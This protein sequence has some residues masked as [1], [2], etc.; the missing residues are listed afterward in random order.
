VRVDQLNGSISSGAITI[1]G[2]SD[3]QLTN[4][5]I[6]G[7]RDSGLYLEGNARPDVHS[8]T[9]AES[10]GPDIEVRTANSLDRVGANEVGLIEIRGTIS[11]PIT[12]RLNGSNNTDYRLANDITIA[13]GATLTIEPG[14]NVLIP[15]TVRDL[16]V[17]GTLLAEGTAQD[18][19]R[20]R[21]G[22]EDDNYGGNIQFYS[23]SEGS[24]LNH[25]SLS[26]LTGG[27][28]DGAISVYG[29]DGLVLTN[30]IIRG[31]YAVG[32]HLDNGA[33]PEIRDNVF[34][35]NGD[36]DIQLHTANS[37]ANVGYNDL[38]TI[39]VRGTIS[40]SILWRLNDQTQYILEEDV[41]ITEGA[42]LTIEPGVD[43][44]L[45][46]SYTD[47]EIDGTL[48]AEGT[49]QDSIRF[50]PGPEGDRFGGNIQFYSSS[51]GSILKYVSINNLTGGLSTGAISVYGT[52]GLV[53]TNS[54]IRGS[55]AVGI[56]LDNN[57]RPEIRD[58]VFSENED[59]DIQ[60]HTANSLANVGYN[61]L[62]TITVRGTIS[63]PILWR[64]NDQTQYI[65]EED[66]RITEGAT[67]TIEPGVDVLLPSSNTDLVI[68][69]TLLA[70]GTAQDS[71]R[72][73][74]GPAGDNYGG[75]IQFRSTSQGSVLNHVKVM[76]L[77]GSG[78][79]GAVSIYGT[80]D[81]HIKNST[82]SGSWES[83]LYIDNGA[84]PV[85]RRNTFENNHYGVIISGSSIPDFGLPTEDGQNIFNNNSEYAVKNNTSGSI[86]AVG[87]YWNTTDPEAIDSKIYDDDEDSDSGPVIFE[88]YLAEAPDFDD[89]DVKSPAI[90]SI[91]P[92]SIIGSNSDQLITVTGSGF[93][94]GAFVILDDLEDEQVP[95]ENPEKTTFV[96][97]TE[98]TRQA[99]FTENAAT[100]S[101]QVENPD[102]SQ[103]N[104]FQFMVEAASDTL[105]EP[106]PDR[107]INIWVHSPDYDFDSVNWINVRSGLG[108]PF[109][110]DSGY[111]GIDEDIISTVCSNANNNQNEEPKDQIKIMKDGTRVGIIYLDLCNLLE[112]D[113][114]LKA[115]LFIDDQFDVPYIPKWE[116]YQNSDEVL[117]SML[118]IPQDFLE[119]GPISNQVEPVLGVHGVSGYYPYW[120]P[121]I[122]S[123]LYD[124]Q[125]FDFWQFYYPYDQPINIS[126]RQLEDALDYILGENI[127]GQSISYQKEDLKILAHS[128]G[129]LV[130]R[131]HIQ[132]DLYSDRINKLVMLGTPNHG[133]YGSYL[134]TTNLLVAGLGDIIGK[135]PYA[136][137]YLEMVPGSNF[138][139][140][141]N[142]MRPINL[143]NQTD[144]SYITVGGTKTRLSFLN[145][146]IIGQNDGFVSLSS[147]SLTEFGVP[148]IVTD[149]HHTN[150]DDPANDNGFPNA[151]NLVVALLSDNYAEIVNYDKYL[152]HIELS[153]LTDNIYNSVSTDEGIGI[154]NIPFDKSD[155]SKG[156]RAKYHKGS[157]RIFS[158]YSQPNLEDDD[159]TYRILG[160][161]NTRDNS[162]LLNT[163]KSD[164]GVRSFE[165]NN[166]V[167]V[168]RYARHGIRWIKISGPANFMFKSLQA[169]YSDPILLLKGQRMVMHANVNLSSSKKKNVSEIIKNIDSQIDTALVYIEL[170]DKSV[171]NEIGVNL[172]SPSGAT[173]TLQNIPS[174]WEAK[175]NMEQGYAYFQIP[176]PESGDW[177]V[178]FNSDLGNVYVAAA[179]ESEINIASSVQGFNH[180]TSDRVEIIY[181]T[182]GFEQLDQ[183]EI[184]AEYKCYN[185]EN[186]QIVEGMLSA[187]PDSANRYVSDFTAHTNSVYCVVNTQ[188]SGIIG[189]ETIIRDAF[190]RVDFNDNISTGFSS[191]EARN[192]DPK[193]IKLDQNYPNPFN[194]TT[195]IRFALPKAESVKLEVFNMLGQRVT[196]LLDE[197]KS[198]GMHTATFDASNLSSG[199]YIYRL[200]AG[201]FVETRKLTLIK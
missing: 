127:F 26:N 16:E 84:D 52:D 95:F 99:T 145:K 31:S 19:I 196:I 159:F 4:S 147:T 105:I 32:I 160:V 80:E 77:T 41:R 53:L 14:V 167:E 89:G 197:K 94:E 8:N 44:I 187:S 79:S 153:N 137:A 179:I 164:I 49:T 34:F 7:S 163:S 57:A 17:Y 122:I 114:N 67:L 155:Y 173:Y 128:M 175:E 141:L 22:R 112:T 139:S 201:E 102:G 69:G 199:M 36:E 132:S 59:E 50:R 200:Q 156:I 178:N 3:V 150:T 174:D 123:E 188:A 116:Y 13:E 135:D 30:S 56:H 171:G 157:L 82:L 140:N 15:S 194:P 86:L 40:E 195:T 131:S 72:F 146:E 189:S 85:I 97:S 64:L 11:T 133:S 184:D 181:E 110:K 23:S 166:T 88:P 134:F 2:I 38:A 172:S 61:D 21:P 104:T 18:S 117:V 180:V 43:V 92:N 51:E 91:E 27:L 158:E 58:N 162:F 121:N 93:V 65:L 113:K 70:E 68:D 185:E 170:P 191:D 118:V 103:S 81:V 46:S 143:N 62:A 142:K 55:Y 119:E 111:W 108:S 87:N 24:I 124:E 9:F 193:E 54:I 154:I 35:D 152:G 109:E 183:I 1:D 192:V 33:R 6:S 176:G 186:N 39:T 148:L 151:K 138:L 107:R 37:L 161:K 12:W 149:L 136:P 98:L 47:L 115:I 5:T 106:V 48:L 126:A 78:D 71:I 29:T 90:T 20:F 45:P 96:S 76:S 190:S 74:P 125:D 120:G 60:L 25:V 144:H 42:T 73:R 165:S 130:S 63:E 83:G 10:G 177:K 66:V 169:N 198:A 100:W 129:G 101:A 168:G 28:S 75:N 182:E